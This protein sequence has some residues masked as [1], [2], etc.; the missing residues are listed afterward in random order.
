MTRRDNV[1]SRAAVRDNRGRCDA[2]CSIDRS[3]SQ[4]NRG[5]IRRL[6]HNRADSS[7]GLRVNDGWL[8]VNHRWTCVHNRWNRLINDNWRLLKDSDRRLPVYE[9]WCRLRIY[10]L[11]DLRLRRGRLHALDLSL[12]GRYGMQQPHTS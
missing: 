1:R 12:S 4:D 7:N 11:L 10:G 2:S 8:L 6:D 9:G 3:C 5:R